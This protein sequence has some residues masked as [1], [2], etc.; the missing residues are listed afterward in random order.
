VLDIRDYGAIV[1]STNGTTNTAAIQQALDDAAVQSGGWGSAKVLIPNTEIQ[2]DTI[3]DLASP[4]W[5]WGN[6]I[7]FEGGG[8]R[9]SMLRCNGGPCVVVAKHPRFWRME[10]TTVVDNS[11]VVRV[12]KPISSDT[13]ANWAAANPVLLSG[14]IAISTTVDGPN[15]CK[16]GP[17]AWNSLSYTSADTSGESAFKDLGLYKTDLYEFRSAGAYPPGSGR[18]EFAPSMSPGQYFGLRSRSGVIEARFPYHP[19]A[20]GDAAQL[21]NS[22]T[23]WPNHNKI[24][25][26]FIH[27]NHSTNVYGGIAGC[28]GMGA[29]DPW[30]L[31]GD[32]TNYVFDLALTDS[33][34]TR[35]TW[36]RCKFAQTTTTGIHRVA[37]QFD[38]DNGTVANRIIAFVD[39]VR[40]ALTIENFLPYVAQGPYYPLNSNSPSTSDLTNLWTVW[41]RV[42]PWKN[43]DFHVFG[44]AARIGASGELG[45]TP[46]TDYTLIAVAAFAKQIYNTTTV[47]GAQTKLGGST[48]ADD[49][50][51]WAWT[52][53][54]ESDGTVLG[55]V[56]NSYDWSPNDNV[57]LNVNCRG[58]ARQR[59]PVWGYI[60]PKG[61][62]FNASHDNAIRGL[63]FRRMDG[64]PASCGLLM[65]PVINMVELED[66][67][68]A[69]A[70]YFASIGTM[71]TYVSYYL[72]LRSIKANRMIHL[73]FFTAD[74]ETIEFGYT[75]RCALRLADSEF[76]LRNFSYPGL[77]A[78]HEAFLVDGSNVIIQDGTINSE[79][80]HF[81]PWGALFQLSR[82][83]DNGPNS[84]TIRNVNIG[85][86]GAPFIRLDDH[87]GSYDA[88]DH[89]IDIDAVK[90]LMAGPVVQVVGSNWAGNVRVA[91]DNY[92][93]ELV[94]Y[95]NGI[96]GPNFCDVRTIDEKGYGIPFS[97]GFIHDSHEVR[98]KRV[99]EGG[100]SLWKPWAPDNPTTTFYQGSNTP[101]TW[102]AA[103]VATSSRNPNAMSANILP[104]IHAACTLPW[105]DSGNATTI[106]H[107]SVMCSFSR[108]ALATILAGASAPT[109]THLGL[110]WGFNTAFATLGTDYPAG[111]FNLP[112]T[113]NSGKWASASA[114]SKATSTTL[115]TEGID[116]PAWLIYL[117]R[118][119]FGSINIGGSSN[120]PAAFVFQTNVREPAHWVVTTANDPVIASGGL[121]IRRPNIAGWTTYAANKIIDWMVDGTLG[122]GG[123]WYFGLSKTAVNTD[124]G[125]GI[126]EPSTGS[127]ARVSVTMNSTNWGEWYDSGFYANKTAIEFPTPSGDWGDIT[128]WF[129]SDAAS[130]GNIIA[131]GPLNRAIRVVNGAPKPTFYPGAFQVQL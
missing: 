73:Q 63:A 33:N 61:T 90:G 7:N 20:H 69:N 72:R 94:A 28:G 38:P 57:N 27:Y 18:A 37:I 43:S 80:K 129:V 88:R 45:G 68:P 3:Y 85:T 39:G 103:E 122:L 119:W 112:P 62:L 47:G 92:L 84:L 101:P 4:L 109:R 58:M 22:C 82:I 8:K 21:T 52:S 130:G 12:T 65:G 6:N 11:G 31:L 70:G 50:T 116:V 91:P 17:G 74:A 118:R 24:T 35:R 34:A 98:P 127:Y 114:R 71:N 64:A 81:Q 1:G 128:H 19:L 60:C 111:F 10:K 120:P 14:E 83:P 53:G 32:G 87:Q 9:S 79:E 41:N 25:W 104:G 59:L 97:G 49:S 5:M 95:E 113:T 15:N 66:L 23:S 48:P 100:V 55:W 106:L 30:I 89:N 123:P 36:V 99:P 40:V 107:S 26:E 131:S 76:R 51:V 2:H 124:D 77:S 125:T 117:R 115:T 105:P 29:P 86:F 13:A 78:Q 54:N 56:C 93:N 110:K 75:Y 121:I 102:L 44:E 108:L 46:R 42:A 16:V 96:S 126:T 67:D